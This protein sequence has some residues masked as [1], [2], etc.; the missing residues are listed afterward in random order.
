VRLEPFPIIVAG[1]IF[2]KFD[3]LLGKTEKWLD[4]GHSYLSFSSKPPD[5]KLHV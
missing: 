1:E 4:I 2:E 3:P 5:N